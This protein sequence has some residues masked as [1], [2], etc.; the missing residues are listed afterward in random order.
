MKNTIIKKEINLLGF[1]NSLGSV[2]SITVPKKRR[3]REINIR[4][5]LFKNPVYNKP[6]MSR[7]V[8]NKVHMK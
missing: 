2:F 3:I 5:T 4:V 8:N 1:L 6:S 7:P